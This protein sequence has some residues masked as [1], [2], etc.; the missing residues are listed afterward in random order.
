[1]IRQPERENKGDGSQAGELSEATSD[2]PCGASNLGFVPHTRPPSTQG[3]H[4]L[5]GSASRF[6]GCPLVGAFRPAPSLR[7]RWHN[8]AS[9]QPMIA[10]SINLAPE[11][12]ESIGELVPCLSS[13]DKRRMCIPPISVN[14]FTCPTCTI[15]VFLWWVPTAIPVSKRTFGR[16]CPRSLPSVERSCVEMNWSFN[17]A[18]SSGDNMTTI[19]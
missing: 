9:A 13:F 12:L 4:F 16:A 3:Q 7:G 14:G 18:S 1:M 5:T 2:R 17:F 6:L 8:V 15:T 10:G 11:V 19:A